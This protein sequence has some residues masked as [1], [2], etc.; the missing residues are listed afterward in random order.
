[1][2]TNFNGGNPTTKVT[3]E[4]EMQAMYFGKKTP[5]EVA[6]AVQSITDTWFKP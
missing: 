3:L 1:M 6:Q 5:D 4:N 2:V